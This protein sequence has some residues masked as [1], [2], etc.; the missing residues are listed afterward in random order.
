MVLEDHVWDYSLTKQNLPYLPSY[1][2]KKKKKK[3]VLYLCVKSPQ[4]RKDTVNFSVRLPCPSGFMVE[5][6]VLTNPSL[7]QL[8]LLCF[9]VMK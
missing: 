6:Q 9:K 4:A 5:L 1:I 2:K 8:T 3:C 7:H